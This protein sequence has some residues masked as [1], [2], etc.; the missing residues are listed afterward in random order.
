MAHDLTDQRVRAAVTAFLALGLGPCAAGAAP[1][2]VSLEMAIADKSAVKPMPGTNGSLAQ[3]LNKTSGVITP[4]ANIDSGIQ[5]PTPT[6]GPQS[7][8]VVPPPGT[9]QNQPNIQPK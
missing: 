2:R 6:T 9:P 3:Q 5:K 1:L 8:P 7:M 4:P